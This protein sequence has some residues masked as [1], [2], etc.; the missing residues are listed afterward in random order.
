MMGQATKPGVGI[1]RAAP[2]LD[3]QPTLHGA[4]PMHYISP[5][6]EESDRRALVPVTAYAEEPLTP[7]TE[8]NA[9]VWR[10]PPLNFTDGQYSMDLNT[11]MFIAGGQPPRPPM[12]PKRTPASP[13][14]PCYRC[15]GEHL[16]RDCPE[17]AQPRQTNAGL[18]P[19][20]TWFCVDCGIKHLISD[21]PTNP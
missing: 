18:V 21:C 5:E 13:L 17:L 7:L 9:E 14:G 6:S 3:R 19:A 4:A 1:E 16:I 10:T 20:L 11:L 12:Q 2:V 15:G 8:E